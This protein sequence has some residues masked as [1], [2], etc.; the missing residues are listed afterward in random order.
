MEVSVKSFGQY[1]GVDYDEIFITNQQGTQISFS[2][3]GA[4]INRWG[5]LQPSGEYE[6]IILGH[7]NA[8]EVFE[9]AS[10]YGATIGRV[11][12]RIELGKATINGESI[13]FAKNNGENHLHGG[14]EGFDLQKFDYKIIEQAEQVC[15]EFSLYDV[16]GHNH[17]PGNLSL[18][19]TFIYNEANEW[20]VEYE[21]VTDA[22]TLFNPTNHVYFNLNGDNEQSIENHYLQV[23]S[24]RYMP[25][26]SDT[27][28][29]GSLESVEDTVFDLREPVLLS[30][31]VRAD[32]PQFAYTK[33]YDHPWL[34]EK[35]A[36]KA[37]ATIALPAKNRKIEMVTSEV[38]VVIYTHGYLTNID[39]I[40]Q[41]PLKAFAGITLE[42]QN[43]PNA[44]NNPLFGDTV[45]LPGEVY[46]SRTTYKLTC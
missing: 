17:Y 1:Q 2:N 41:Q 28:P 12:G 3:L 30:K 15:V 22:P 39:K 32:E 24:Q 46:T 26:K 11:A 36:D 4:R 27:M 10:Y 6:Q 37:H 34:L 35:V 38:A 19:V 45:L 13:Q 33:G 9:S 14:F 7:Q 20:T 5:I 23:A 44:I 21:A 43:L 16:A 8:Q 18:K 29:V 42:T 31:R 25:L 40:W